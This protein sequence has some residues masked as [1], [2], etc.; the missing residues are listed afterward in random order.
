MSPSQALA[1]LI[2]LPGTYFLEHTFSTHLY[3]PRSF[4]SKPLLKYCLFSEGYLDHPIQNH[5]LFI[6]TPKSYYPPPFSFPKHLW[7][8]SIYNLFIITFA[9][10]ISHQLEYKLFVCLVHWYI[11]RTR[12]IIVSWMNKWTNMRLYISILFLCPSISAWK[13]INYLLSSMFF[14]VKPC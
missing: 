11:P 5:N 13:A 1:L 14:F 2:L 12:D 3:I 6:T 4:T 9:H 10:C 8:S 7:F